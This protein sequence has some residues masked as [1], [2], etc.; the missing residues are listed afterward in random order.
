M[1]QAATWLQGQ[2]WENI[3]TGQQAV[4]STLQMEQQEKPS[5]AD[6]HTLGAP[7]CLADT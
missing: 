3:Q 7:L 2:A 6:V 4:F 1:G 5:R